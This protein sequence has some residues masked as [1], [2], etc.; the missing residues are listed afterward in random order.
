MYSRALLH[1]SF[2]IDTAFWARRY[3]AR[4]RNMCNLRFFAVRQRPMTPVLPRS[5][6]RIMLRQILSC[7][8]APPILKGA[9]P[10]LHRWASSVGTSGTVSIAQGRFT[11]FS[12]ADG[13]GRRANIH[14]DG[15]FEDDRWCWIFR[16]AADCCACNCE[17][18]VVQCVSLSVQGAWGRHEPAPSNCHRPCS[19]DVCEGVEV[20]LFRPCMRMHL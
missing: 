6:S 15:V 12:R 7:E 17:C 10:L 8:P 9:S 20:F 2:Y 14:T 13:G 11:R 16:P 5:L 19:R 3:D 4:S 1:R 18:R